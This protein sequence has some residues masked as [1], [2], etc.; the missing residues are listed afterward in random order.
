[1]KEGDEG[2]VISAGMLLV[3]LL[4]IAGAEFLF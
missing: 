4:L 2:I 3:A 1:M